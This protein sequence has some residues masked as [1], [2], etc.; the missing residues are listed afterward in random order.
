MHI[1]LADDEEHICRSLRELLV[2]LGYDVACAYDGEQA[3]RYLGQ[4]A[5][6]LVVSDIRMPRIDGIQLLERIKAAYP[7]TP[8]VLFTGH[9]DE[10][11]LKHARRLGVASFLYKPISVRDLIQAIEEL[12]P[13]IQSN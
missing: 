10:A 9:G 11:L 13:T 4:R 3:L 1:L 2:D 7:D 12:E 5:V 8:V 6:D